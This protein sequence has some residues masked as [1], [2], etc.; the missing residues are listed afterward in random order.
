VI[1]GKSKGLI[2]KNFKIKDLTPH[3]IECASYSSYDCVGKINE[4]VLS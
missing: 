3:T 4:E 1:C 2:L